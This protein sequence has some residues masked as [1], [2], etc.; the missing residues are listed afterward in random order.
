MNN[1]KT[2]DEL[3]QFTTLLTET[4][5]QL[6]NMGGITL[7]ARYPQP[8][9]DRTY[10]PVYAAPAA[11]GHL[12][13][14]RITSD[15]IFVVYDGQSHFTGFELTLY[16][17][18]SGNGFTERAKISELSEIFAT[19]ERLE[20]QRQKAL[21]RCRHRNYKLVA[22]LGRCYNRYQCLNCNTTFEV[23]SSD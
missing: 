8:W 1:S 6:S 4:Y 23:D 18:D 22:N 19:L 17:P 2:T 9:N 10:K 14:W 20:T 5:T 16:V 13:D 7:P 12:P 21:Q 11:Q 3:A 15:P